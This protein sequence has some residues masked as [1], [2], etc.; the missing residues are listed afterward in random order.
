MLPPRQ[1]T[2]IKRHCSRDQLTDGD[3]AYENRASTPGWIQ[4]RT[5][6]CL[7]IFSRAIMHEKNFFKLEAKDVLPNINHTQ[8]AE[9]AEKCRFCSW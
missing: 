4:R 6:L 8:A 3:R 9:L 5:A 7:M 2:E 1:A